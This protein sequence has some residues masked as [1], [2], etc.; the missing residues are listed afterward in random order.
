MSEE[1][2]A[3]KQFRNLGR[4]LGLLR[5]LRGLSQAEL[6]RRAH[7]GKG[8]LSRYEGGRLPKLDALERLLAVLEVRQET[9]FS[10]VALLEELHENLSGTPEDL[11]LPSI[12]SMEP[13]DDAFAASFR[14]LLALQ[15][16]VLLLLCSGLHL[17]HPRSRMGSIDPNG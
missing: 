13:V 15:R 12:L 14:A 4:A 1:R 8:P 6:A 10:I 11:L 2:E 7:V 9:F 3:T 5:D 17:P 16:S